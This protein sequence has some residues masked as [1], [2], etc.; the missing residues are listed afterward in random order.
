MVTGLIDKLSEAESNLKQPQITDDIHIIMFSSLI[1]ITRSTV[2]LLCPS[3][4]FLS[5]SWS[6]ALAK[7]Q[8]AQRDSQEY[9]TVRAYAPLD[10]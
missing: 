5:G 6:R 10:L 2:F 9:C 7:M 8:Q 4:C 3:E 1:C